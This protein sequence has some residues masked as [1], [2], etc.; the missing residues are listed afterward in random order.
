MNRR[1]FIKCTTFGFASYSIIAKANAI[2]AFKEED[3]PID[4]LED[5]TKKSEINESNLK[6]NYRVP[7]LL[8]PGS[9]VA[10]A[11]PSS[12]TNIW[13]ISKAINAF[14]KFGVEIEIGKIIKNQNSKNRYLAAPDVERAAE[15]MEFVERRDIDA[16]IS[17]RGGYGSMRIAD[18]L[19][20]DKIAQN[21]KIYIGFSD[22]TFLLNSISQKAHLIT[23]HGPVG[24]SSFSEFSQKYLFTFIFENQ[25]KDVAF[26]YPN[27]IQLVEGKAMGRIVG[28]NLTMIAASLGTKHEI[29]TK[30]AILFFEDINEQ[31]YQIDRMLTQLKLAGKLD[32]IKGI[33][34]GQFSSLKRR[35]AF[36][37][38]Y[39]YTLLE[40]FEQILSPLGVP[41][42]LNIPIG[43]ISE[44][45]TIPINSIIE[46]DTKTKTITFL[47]RNLETKL[48]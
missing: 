37:P 20:Y 47:Y 21:P 24:V 12:V 14:K 3:N 19:D 46:L 13:E 10:F 15:F 7:P 43:H 5:S 28:G 35:K 41:I 26:T 6:S 18:L 36:Y 22:F 11:S 1:K 32:S 48:D 29:N 16:I 40:V 33:L 39:S 17:A 27:A 30:D 23:Y 31:P 44:Q 34:I 4:D 9:R 45:I 38:S 2:D 8:V 25:P 42:L